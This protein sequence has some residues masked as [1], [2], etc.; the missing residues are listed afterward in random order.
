MLATLFLL[1]AQVMNASGDLVDAKA[2]ARKAPFPPLGYRAIFT[3]HSDTTLVVRTFNRLRKNTAGDYR[4]DVEFRDWTTDV[5]N[6]FCGSV[7]A[8]DAD[9]MKDQKL[10]VVDLPCGMYNV[11]L[12]A[13]RP[14]GGE[15]WTQH[16]FYEKPCGGRAPWEGNRL[17]ID[18]EVP[19]PWTVPDFKSDGFRCWNREIRFGGQGLVSSLLSAGQ[20]LLSAP[21]E[22]RLN[23]ST[24]RFDSQLADRRHSEADYA[25]K[26]VGAP[27]DVRCH[28][29]FDGFVRF[30]VSYSGD[31]ESLVVRIPL[32][33]A[34][35]RAFDDCS[36]AIGK[37][38]FGRDEA[39]SLTNNPALVP[40]W[41]TGDET[42]GLMGG[43]NDL[44][45]W[46]VR[47]LASGYRFE[48][49]PTAAQ[50]TMTVVDER[51]SVP[52]D[53]P[54]TFSF[55]LEA[56]PTKP[57][58]LKEAAVPT[59]KRKS[60]SN[61]MAEFWEVKAD[62]WMDEK[63]REANVRDMDNGKLVYWFCASQGASPKFPWWGWFGG[64]WAL[65]GDPGFMIPIARHG[66]RGG[67]TW[68]CPNAQ[69]FLDYK[70]DS[71]NWLVHAPAYRTSRIYLDLAFP[72]PC[73]NE[74][75]GCRHRDE[76]GRWVENW[77]IWS[78]REFHKRLYKI[79]KKKDPEGV[80]F[81][82][83]QFQRAPSDVFFDRL[84]MGEVY[85]RQMMKQKGK[86][87]Y[88][89]LLNPA[90]MQVQYGMRANEATIDLIPQINRVL[91]TYCRDRLS[92]YSE[93]DPFYRRAQFY[94]LAYVHLH[95]LHLYSDM[96]VTGRLF[97]S[98]E[99]KFAELGPDTLFLSYYTE[100][101]PVRAKDLLWALHQGVGKSIL[102]LLN[103][104]EAP[105]E[106][107]VCVDE[108]AFQKQL[109]FAPRQARFIYF[110]G[111]AEV[112]FDI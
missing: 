53:A 15:L 57:K 54:R 86:I 68:A 35:L 23:G 42:V 90:D 31:V 60:Y 110:D 18:D 11:H 2:P 98:V 10:S 3:D 48:A 47:N 91:E 93:L 51:I 39:A 76:F 63:V 101:R 32:V 21:V 92:G 100:D 58:N 52:A 74:V 1:A 24:L 108:L 40:F 89:G 43:V 67:W 71:M 66:I 25:L 61:L 6:V 64:D 26:A 77:T 55:Y 65:Y 78:L 14:D 107:E 80:L 88:F 81:G 17:G 72:K 12:T 5:T 4:L 97:G 50:V 79:L 105:V 33:R 38:M 62:G 94:F 59:A 56:T 8:L 104:S 16:L 109:K 82:H 37:L 87:S 34:R 96:A 20:E 106:A 49:T 36:C 102:V 70:V 95:N 30:D 112:G 111:K 41:W 44:G 29:E 28:A 85:E 84:A 45:G 19:P 103:D 27:V 9:G 73:K 69:S 46:H 99:K 13:R 75:H 83:L 22:V 7:A